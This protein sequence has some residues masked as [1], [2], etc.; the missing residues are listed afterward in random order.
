MQRKHVVLSWLSA[1]REE[2]ELRLP[3]DDADL[4]VQRF[5]NQDVPF[6]IEYH[7]GTL[8]I[9]PAALASV[10]TRDHRSSPYDGG[11]IRLHLD[12][13][14]QLYI[15]YRDLDLGETP[16]GE[17]VWMVMPAGWLEAVEALASD[18]NGPRTFA[19]DV[20]DWIEGN[21]GIRQ[22]QVVNP[23]PNAML[24]AQL[25]RHTGGIIPKVEPDSLRHADFRVVM[26]VY[27]PREASTIQCR[28]A[29]ADAAAAEPAQATAN[30]GLPQA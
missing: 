11:Y 30:L 13:R 3:A 8:T 15:A 7:G 28:W 16:E 17:D 22:W 14:G 21:D 20:Y 2:I 12:G 9:N 1:G 25:G 19:N 24:L 26:Y 27:G 18:P 23:R 5:R 29:I 10:W 6:D 4:L